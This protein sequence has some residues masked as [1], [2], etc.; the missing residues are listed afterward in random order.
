MVRIRIPTL[1]E[2]F[3]LDGQ[4]IRVELSLLENAKE[5]IRH[6]LEHYLTHSPGPSDFKQAI[7]NIHLGFELALK[8]ALARKHP[9][10]LLERFSVQVIM[11]LISACEMPEVS[12]T[13]TFTETVRRAKELLGLQK[14]VAGFFE[15]LNDLRNAAVHYILKLDQEKVDRQIGWH[16]KASLEEVFCRLL[17]EDLSFLHP[18]QLDTLDKIRCRLDD[19]LAINLSKR[20]GEARGVWSRLSDEEKNRHL[21]DSL[22]LRRPN[23][24]FELCPACGQRSLA[25]NLRWETVDEEADGRPITT[26]VPINFK[27]A[28]CP[29]ELEGEELAYYVWTVETWRG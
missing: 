16:L 9:A 18:V 10:Y 24:Y 12:R 20:I 14:E 28:C 7:L 21:R 19:P 5:S 15:G 8:E 2:M 26:P 17:V 25:E 1:K 3:N 11:A 22:V 29:F 4:W 13:I 23:A 6:G 27:C